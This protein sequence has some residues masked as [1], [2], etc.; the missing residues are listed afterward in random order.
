MFT[1]FSNISLEKMDDMWH[2]LSILSNEMLEKFVNI[3][4]CLPVT[5]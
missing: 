5:S 4:F 1:K 2:M 3:V